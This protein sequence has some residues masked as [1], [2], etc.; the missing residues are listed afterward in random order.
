MFRIRVISNFYYPS[1]KKII[2]NIQNIIRKQFPY[3]K[4]EYIKNIPAQIEDPLRFQFKTILFAADD[5]KNNVRGFSLLFHFPDLKFCF[6]DYI[7]TDKKIIGRGIGGALY[8]R[9]REETFSLKAIGLFYECLPDDPVL[10]KDPEILKQNIARLKFYERYG[11]TPIVNTKYETPIKEGGDNPPYLVF[12]DCGTQKVLTRNKAKKIVRAILERKYKDI[13][14]DEYIEMVVNSFK[15]DPVKLRP[16]KYIKNEKIIS[17]LKSQ[18]RL[19][20]KRKIILIVSEKHNIHHV[21]DRGY[22]EAPVR[23]SSILN[24]IEKSDLF[25]RLKSEHYHVKHIKEVHEIDFFNYLK[26]VCKNVEPNRS[27]YP[28]VFPIRNS[29]R[30]PKELPIRA[31]Y[32]CIDTFTPINKNAFSAAIH[33]VDCAL[34]GADKILENHQLVYVLVR[35]PGHHAERKAFGG[36]CY[37]NSSAIAAHYLSNFGKVAML[38]IDYH[39]GNGQQDI[40]YSRNDV[41]T[42]S[43]HGHPSFAYPYF[44]GFSDEKGEGEGFGFNNNFPLPEKID[45]AKYFET[46]K[47]AL[48]KIKKFKPDFLVVPFGLDTAKGDPT[49]TWL[50]TAESFKEIG[51]LIGKLKLPT[52][53]VQEGGYRTKVL[54]INALSFFNGLWVGT[55]GS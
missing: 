13:C 49:G 22:V 39:H 45:K 55:Y 10:C 1:N 18:I 26:K 8:E 32:Y 16:I 35:P 21:R 27:V 28:Y 34:S 46:L 41:L 24:E 51:L 15:D 7:A 6:L 38:D 9:M 40:F 42:I 30:M 23:I 3:E 48:K 44:S 11:A 17:R 25:L 33:A 12:D 2:N 5:F 29:A 43:I 31:G 47:T 36:F 4:E 14:T 53:V 37:F 52:L 50:L 54:G 20:E 19:T